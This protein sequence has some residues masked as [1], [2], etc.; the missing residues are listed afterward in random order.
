MKQSQA[1]PP[2][3][4]AAVA[5]SLMNMHAHSPSKESSEKIEQRAKKI[6]KALK[7]IRSPGYTFPDESDVS[8]SI[9]RATDKD[10]LQL[11]IY[12]VFAGLDILYELRAVIVDKETFLPALM[13]MLLAA[14]KAQEAED[15]VYPYEIRA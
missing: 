8:F 2:L 11:K 4:V 7:K 1:F 3:S 10:D 13:R 15:T 6:D 5:E 12:L 9:I 14:K